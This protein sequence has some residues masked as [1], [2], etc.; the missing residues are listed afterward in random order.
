MFSFRLSL[1]IVKYVG[2]APETHFLW[3]NV[4]LYLEDYPVYL[5]ILPPLKIE[6]MG[7]LIYSMETQ[8]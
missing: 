8:K 7:R 1:R 5:Y 2:K 4:R 6:Y 3:S